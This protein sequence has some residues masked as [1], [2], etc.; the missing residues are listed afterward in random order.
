[1][2]SYLLNNA[3]PIYKTASY[4]H[5][6]PIYWARLCSTGIHPHA[7]RAKKILLGVSEREG[8]QARKR[9]SEKV[10]RYIRQHAQSKESEL[11]QYRKSH[12]GGAPDGSCNH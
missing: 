6:S 3:S 11:W 10:V 8:E 9:T 1:M 12:F 5:K 2:K 4:K 7:I